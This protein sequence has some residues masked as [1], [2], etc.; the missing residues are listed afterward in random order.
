[1]DTFQLL[2]SAAGLGLLAGIRLY[3]TAFALGLAIRAGWFEPGAGMSGLSILAETPVLVGSGLL[4]FVE[5]FADK[6]PWFDSIWDGVHTFIRPIGAAALGMTALGS[7]DPATTTLIGLISGGAAFT[8]HASK[9]A[10]RVAVNHSP[11]PFSNWA[12]SFAEDLMV[13]LGLWVV[14]EHPL[15]TAFLA[16]AFLSIFVLLAR[17]V[18]R[19]FRSTFTRFRTSF[20]TPV[21]R[22]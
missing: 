13:P 6:I 5:F 8:S 22:A 7:F 17:A 9:A 14:I 3:F 15:I 2:G 20:A 18:W 10:T 11:E 16:A 4:L 19:L 1:M 12:L 21:R